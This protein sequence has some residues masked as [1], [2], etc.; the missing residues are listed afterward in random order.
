MTGVTES[1][2]RCLSERKNNEI[3][4]KK[5]ERKEEEE[6]K[7]QHASALTASLASWRIRAMVVVAVVLQCGRAVGSRG[8]FAGR[9][10]MYYT[11]NNGIDDRNSVRYVYNALCKQSPLLHWLYKLI[12]NSVTSQSKW[13]G[14]CGAGRSSSNWKNG[15]SNENSK[16]NK[17][18]YFHPL[19][20]APSGWRRGPGGKYKREE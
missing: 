8:L 5:P 4:K 17:M 18:I 7:Q 10:K 12:F 11:P 6:E 15:A 13:E 20:D 16:N 9:N 2:R 19:R 1:E 3:K 14:R